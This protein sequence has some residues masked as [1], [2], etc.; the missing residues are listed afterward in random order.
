MLVAII[1]RID[2][3]IMKLIAGVEHDKPVT[4]HYEKQYKN[5]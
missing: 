1:C 4:I 2:N 3:A 5:S